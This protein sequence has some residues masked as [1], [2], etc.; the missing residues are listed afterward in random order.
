MFDNQDPAH[1]VLIGE[2]AVVMP[3]HDGPDPPFVLHPFW[4][5][6]VGEAV[7]WLGTERNTDKV[8]GN[9][10]APLLQ[11]VNHTQWTVSIRSLTP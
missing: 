7:F 4:E 8:I 3:N 5:G 6:G 10:Y 1:K 9:A 11:N 2:Y